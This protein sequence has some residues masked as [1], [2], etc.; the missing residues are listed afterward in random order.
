MAPVR[1]AIACCLL[2]TL[3]GCGDTGPELVPVSGIV[4]I[5]GQPLTLGSIQVI[6]AGYRPAYGQIGP[7]GRF[8]L[9]TF[10]T[11][12]GVVRGEHQAAVSACE[13]LNAGQQKWHAPK[14]YLDATESGLRIVVDGPSKNLEVN[15]SWN[16]GG[17]FIERTGD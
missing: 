10:K 13:I 7:D 2:T 11:G 5:D 15:L 9:T 16:G 1:Y 12:D 8:T 4:T 17:P 3:S 6:P 14:R